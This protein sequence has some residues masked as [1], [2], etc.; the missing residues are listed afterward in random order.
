[1]LLSLQLCAL[2][3]YILVLNCFHDC[4]ENVHISIE[5]CSLTVSACTQYQLWN[6]YEWSACV[7][8][9]RT[10]PVSHSYHF[11]SFMI[12]LMIIVQGLCSGFQIMSVTSKLYLIIVLYIHVRNILHQNSYT[13]WHKTWT[14]FLESL[15][16]YLRVRL[17]LSVTSEGV[18][19]SDNRAN[20]V[21]KR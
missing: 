9:R 6:T 19:A 14:Y 8:W 20:A 2:R 17:V 3:L 21:N 11:D 16:L 12:C 18:W 7:H 1:V 15:D 13:V 10:E 4:G 5:L